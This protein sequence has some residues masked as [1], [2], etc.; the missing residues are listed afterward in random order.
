VADTP[1]AAELPKK[2][3][4]IEKPCKAEARLD[5]AEPRQLRLCA[6]GSTRVVATQIAHP[7][8]RYV[9]KI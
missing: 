3:V 9:P 4:A 7:C 5:V 1:Q 6:K 8:A 2:F